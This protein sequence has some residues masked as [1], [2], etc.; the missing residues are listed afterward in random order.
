MAIK[1]STEMPAKALVLN[2]DE[3]TKKNLKNEMYEDFG[4]IF[5]REIDTPP[6]VLYTKRVATL[7]VPSN[8][9]NKHE[10]LVKDYGVSVLFKGE[11]IYVVQT[12]ISQNGTLVNM[13]SVVADNL[14]DTNYPKNLVVK[15][16]R[17]GGVADIVYVQKVYF[18][19]ASER[20]YL[21]NILN[22]IVS[23]HK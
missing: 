1:Q 21:G 8:I 5:A 17:D 14:P 16:D 15:S 19:S 4:A 18:D 13:M 6:N 2:K 12:P 22:T 10:P 3:L 7:D 23:N 20:E 11:E 9:T